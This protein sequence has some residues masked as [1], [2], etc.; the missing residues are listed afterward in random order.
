MMIKIERERKIFFS[1]IFNSIIFQD[2][3]ARRDK[4][5]VIGSKYSCGKLDFLMNMK[6]AE[7]FSS[8]LSFL[9]FQVLFLCHEKATLKREREKASS[10]D[11]YLLNY[12][13]VCVCIE[14][15]KCQK[16]KELK[17]NEV[18]L[19]SIRCGR[20]LSFLLTKD[21]KY[22]SYKHTHTHFLPI[23]FLFSICLKSQHKSRTIKNSIYLAFLAFALSLFSSCDYK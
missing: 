8:L 18:K 14:D 17:S 4:F 15:P 16:R 2:V 11:D 9:F 1:I 20:V 5:R 3:I 23:S 12:I 10:K 13:Y 7:K 21:I 19:F 22:F 6:R